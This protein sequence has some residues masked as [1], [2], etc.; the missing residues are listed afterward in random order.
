[1][2]WREETTSTNRPGGRLRSDDLV[3]S[4]HVNNLGDGLDPWQSD[5]GGDDGARDGHSQAVT[6][7]EG[8]P[9]EPETSSSGLP[10]LSGRQDVGIFQNLPPLC[11]GV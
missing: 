2:T 1:M 11:L 4:G 6:S 9:R 3:V 5:A 10:F 8:V 7:V